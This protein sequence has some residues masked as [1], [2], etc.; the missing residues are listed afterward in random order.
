MLGKIFAVLVLLAFSISIINGTTADIGIA[1]ATGAASAVQLIISL[2][3]M[4]C[5]WSGI[6]RVL[7]YAGAMDFIAKLISPVL[8]FVFPETYKK[9]LEGDSEAASALGSVAA[10]IG[11]NMLGVG[12]AATP[13]GIDAMKRFASLGGDEYLKSGKATRDMAMFVVINCASLQ[14]IP[15]TIVA[16]RAAAGASTP[17]AVIPAIWIA[18]I[19]TTVFAVLIAKLLSLVTG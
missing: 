4:L 3:G 15:T 13:I 14:L 11:A 19:C 5:F 16:L 18:S 6:I 9:K 17:F 7:K 10:N 2:A 12:N 1:A 8:R